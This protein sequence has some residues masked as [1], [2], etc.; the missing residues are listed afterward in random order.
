MATHDP[1]PLI[2]PID[3][4]EQALRKWTVELDGKRVEP[5]LVELASRFGVLRYGWSVSGYDGWSCRELGGGG[6]IAVPYAIKDGALWLG[7]IEQVRA[8]QGG[9]VLNVP[10]GFLEAGEAHASAAGRELEEETGISGLV[11]VELAGS[12]VN[13]NSAYF[14]TP[15][16]GE[17][18]RFYALELDAEWLVEDT[19]GYRLREER[20]AGS[21]AAVAERKREQIGVLRF[22]AWSEAA[23]LSDMFTVAAVARLLA[24]LQRHSRW[25]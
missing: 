19:R 17:G 23:A 12:P 25:P 6:V 3:P 20:I 10:R 1:E 2:R 5:A 4:A 21:A 9:V 13:A 16:A 11:P 22:I 14:E 15:N 7:V 8:N 24:E 18:A